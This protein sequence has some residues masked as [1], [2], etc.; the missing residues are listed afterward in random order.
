M[1]SSLYHGTASLC[2]HEQKV[3]FPQGKLC[4]KAAHLCPALSPCTNGHT[5]GSSRTGSLLL[6]SAH[7]LPAASS[8]N[9]HFCLIKS[10]SGPEIGCGCICS[11]SA[12]LVITPYLFCYSF[13]SSFGN[14]SPCKSITT[15]TSL[16]DEASSRS[17]RRDCHHQTISSPHFL[18]S[19]LTNV[20]LFSTAQNVT[21]FSSGAEFQSFTT[22]QG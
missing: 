20:Q 18:S 11:A 1:P 12:C 2:I 22:F 21:R 3:A 19:S 4:R 13:R 17:T 10:W 9:G 14:P 16:P 6:S 7:P 15:N 5:P 8:W